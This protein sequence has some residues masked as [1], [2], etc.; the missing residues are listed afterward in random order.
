MGD[1]MTHNLFLVEASRAV[2]GGQGGGASLAVPGHVAVLGGAADGQGV[3]AVG[4]AVAVT[5][6][7]LPAAV[8]GRPHKDGAQP[9]TTLRRQTDTQ[10]GK[11]QDR[12]RETRRE[13]DRE[14]QTASETEWHH[15]P[16]V[17]DRRVSL[18]Q[19]DGFASL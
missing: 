7:P 11:S 18:D 8:T 17:S 6:V 10:R 16:G 13:R 2:G 19:M 1:C 15:D 9:T 3:D 4:V 14:R 12:D 5:A